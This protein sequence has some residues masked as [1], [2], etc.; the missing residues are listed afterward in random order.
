MENVE[1][2]R[3]FLVDIAENHPN[4]KLCESVLTAYNIIFESDTGI[5]VTETDQADQLSTLL[6]NSNMSGDDQSKIF[7][8]FVEIDPS[9]IYPQQ[10]LSMI[11]SNLKRKLAK[12]EINV[13]DIGEY[14]GQYA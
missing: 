5:K 4:K 14:L 7:T 9:K 1:K 13:D 2:Y 10:T 12:E 3:E 8:K 6:K 11:F